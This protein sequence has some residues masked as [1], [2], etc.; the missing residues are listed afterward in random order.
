MTG[1][2][3]V[4]TITPPHIEY[5]QLSPLLLVFGLG[6]VGVLIE[7]FVPRDLRRPAHLIITLGGLAVAFVLTIVVAATSSLFAHGGHGNVAAMGAVGVDGPT[8]F[9]WGTILVLAFVSVLLIAD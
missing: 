5:G 2:L 7:A 6:V 1:S 8:L 3:A 4:A 9:V